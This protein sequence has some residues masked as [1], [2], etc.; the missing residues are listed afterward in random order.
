MSATDNHAAVTNT[1]LAV[2]EGESMS[3][4]GRYPNIR[5]MRSASLLAEIVECELADPRPQIPVGPRREV[6]PAVRGG[7]LHAEVERE[8]AADVP[9]IAPVKRADLAKEPDVVLAEP[10]ALGAGGDT[11]GVG[12]VGHTGGV[13]STPDRSGDDGVMI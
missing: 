12:G 11:L 7:V 13:A 3:P 1:L 9:A 5:F 2:E 10:E 8:G 4:R 6:G